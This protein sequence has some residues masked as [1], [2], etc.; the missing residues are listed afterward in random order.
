MAVL[1]ADF[2]GRVASGAEYLWWR[3]EEGMRTTIALFRSGRQTGTTCLPIEAVLFDREGGVAAR[4]Q[5][6]LQ[7]E[8]ACIIDSGVAGPWTTAGPINGVLAL[9]VCP[10]PPQ[11]PRQTDST[12]RL[13]PLVT[14]RRADGRIASLHSDQALSLGTSQPQRFTEIVVC[15]SA[16]ERNALIIVNG[17]TPQAA[18]ALTLTVH[19]AA[20]EARNARYAPAMA[21]HTVHRIVLADL[22]ADLPHF[23][24]SDALLV[25]GTFASLDLETRPYVETTGQRWGL[26]HAGDVY[27]WHPRPYLQHAYVDGEVNPMAVVNNDVV[28][29]WVNLLHSHD[30]MEDDTPV[31][32][33][34]YDD[35]GRCVASL[36]R[37]TQARR[38]RLTRFCVSELLE[39]PS[40]PFSGH[41]AITF[42]PEPGQDVPYH[43]QALMEYRSAHV[44]ARVMGW[45]DEWNSDIKRARRSRLG[46][47][48]E[49][50]AYFM[51]W[52]D[53]ELESLVAI[54]NAG[55]SNYQDSATA[56]LTLLG[57]DGP[58]M[59][60]TI[61]I[62]PYASAFFAVG[63]RFPA[64]HEHLKAGA[65]LLII[66]SCSDL[67]SIAF[68]RHRA[69]GA[70]AAEHFLA[71]WDWT[72]THYTE[73]AGS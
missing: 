64:W 47:A 59:K 18:G 27:K 8:R 67:A 31:D 44:V 63:E 36:P 11:D 48:D 13:Y 57:P 70:L 35:T 2:I 26:Y 51:V 5:F 42:S 6:E 72:G 66:S 23:A 40:Q 45:S 32:V 71:L 7:P 68:T 16:D 37:W 19:N 3:S 60:D 24:G 14:W 30:G 55:H 10:D 43:V 65:A 58:V 4:W 25:S 41:I 1:K 50:R 33:R 61:S 49:I 56:E 20:H 12:L 21:P 9:Y 73:A 34:L 29:T 53:A 28:T 52:N 22:F 39:D 69:S 38:H 17:E 62:A 54:A 15:E 46:Q